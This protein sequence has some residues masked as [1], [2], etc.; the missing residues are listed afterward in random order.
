MKKQKKRGSASSRVAAGLRM[1]APSLRHS[2]TA[3][4]A[5]YRH[6][7]CRKGED[8]AV[9]AAARKL[10]TL[11]YRLIRWGRPYVDEGAAAYERRYWEAR[12]KSLAT[13][14]K[15]LGYQLAPQVSPA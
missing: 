2:E 10:A 1:A 3:L 5:Y 4:G 7:A 6:I 13:A 11:I 15:N 12:I 14:A 8:V 9:F